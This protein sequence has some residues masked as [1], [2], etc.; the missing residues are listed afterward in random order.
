MVILRSTYLFAKIDFVLERRVIF[1]F[2]KYGDSPACLNREEDI[3]GRKVMIQGGGATENTTTT[4]TD[5]AIVTFQ[6]V[7]LLI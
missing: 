1:D 4:D 5:R 3:A 2:D 7:L 6:K